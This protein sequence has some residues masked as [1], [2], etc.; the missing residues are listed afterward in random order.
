MGSFSFC[1][2]VKGYHYDSF[3]ALCRYNRREGAMA[4]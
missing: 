4:K 1:H 3:I 2:L